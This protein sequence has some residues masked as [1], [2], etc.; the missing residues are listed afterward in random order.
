MVPM[1][2]RAIDP[3]SVDCEQNTDDVIGDEEY[4]GSEEIEDGLWN[5]VYYDTLLGRFEEE[6][7]TISGAPSLRKKVL[8][9]FPVY[10]VTCLPGCSF[11]LSNAN[12]HE[13]PYTSPSV[14]EQQFSPSL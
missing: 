10:S 6:A 13:G 14:W 2:W 5:F 7:G 4:V 9:M 1:P 3:S 8:P 11:R 12:C